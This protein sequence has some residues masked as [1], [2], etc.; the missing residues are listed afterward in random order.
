MSNIIERRLDINSRFI[1]NSFSDMLKD[2]ISKELLEELYYI[3]RDTLEEIGDRFSACVFSIAKLMDNYGLKR[4]SP[5]EATNT[6]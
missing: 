6:K 2:N 4:R 1:T 3:K 5:S